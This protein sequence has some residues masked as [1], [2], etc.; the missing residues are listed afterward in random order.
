MKNLLITV[1]GL[2]AF[3]SQAQVTKDMG[4]FSD[5]KTTNR[6]KVELIQGSEEKI[7]LDHKDEKDV[8]LTNKNGKLIIKNN[9]KELV[10]DSDYKIVVKV[11]FKELKNITAESG[12]YIVSNK[13]LDANSLKISSNSGSQVNLKLKVTTLEAK[14]FAGA[15][16]TLEG[17][18]TTGTLIGTAG[19]VI[20]AS[21]LVFNDATATVN[22]GGKIEVNASKTVNATTRAGG[23]VNI[24][25]NPKTVTEKSTAGGTIKRVK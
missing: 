13:K 15:N 2:I 14:V 17:S 7:V 3:N 16:I 19:G 10:S 22:A 12:S 5:L 21:K 25:G 8:S 18:G 6:I 23:Y 9:I 4:T 1:V 24:Y 20:D 11:Y